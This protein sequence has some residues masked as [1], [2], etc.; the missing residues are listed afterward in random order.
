M[1]EII[2]A[3]VS[4]FC[5]NHLQI[6]KMDIKSFSCVGLMFIIYVLYTF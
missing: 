2:V 1:K 4:Y 5:K 6:S 3:T